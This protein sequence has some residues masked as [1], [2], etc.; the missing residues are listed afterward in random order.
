M[1]EIQDLLSRLAVSRGKLGR[2]LRQLQHYE[3]F[4]R[5]LYQGKELTMKEKSL[6]ALAIAVVKQCEYCIAVHL[7]EALEAG[8]SDE[9]IFEACGIAILMG[10]GPALGYST[11]VQE[12]LEALRN[13][14]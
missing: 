6:I 12:A 11:F 1:S 5:S 3:M 7:K 4:K 10:G 9:E 14:V 8:V 2:Q 13:T